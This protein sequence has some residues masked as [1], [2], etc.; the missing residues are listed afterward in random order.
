MTSIDERIALLEV[1]LKQEKAKKQQI[2]ARK[3]VAE[4]KTQRSQDTRR[5]I[6]IGAT[7]LAKVEQGE[8]PQERLLSMLDLSLNRSDDR[9]LFDLP[10][11]QSQHP[12][13]T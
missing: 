13:M 10:I 9:A 3:R 11:G 12:V 7:I 1:R 6:L 2:E 5:K 8:W 4:A